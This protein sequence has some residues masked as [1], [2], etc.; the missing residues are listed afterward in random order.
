MNAILFLE[1]WDPAWGGELELWNMPEEKCEL[2]GGSGE[3]LSFTKCLNCCGNGYILHNELEHVIS[4][5]PHFN[6]LV[7]FET[8]DRSYHGVPH[9]IRAP[10]GIY[11]RSLATYWWE[12]GDWFCKRKRATF[13]ALPNVPDTEDKKAWR[14]ERSGSS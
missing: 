2:C 7:I 4:I 1:P 5:H 6:R 8:S 3:T 11:R 13:M 9:K 12:P 10:T 14:R